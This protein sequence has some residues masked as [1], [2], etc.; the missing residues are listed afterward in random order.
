MQGIQMIKKMMASIAAAT[1]ICSPCVGEEGS[2]AQ[3]QAVCN[4]IGAHLYQVET[5]LGEKEQPNTGESNVN[6]YLGRSLDV[7]FAVRGKKKI[8]LSARFSKDHFDSEIRKKDV[9]LSMLLRERWAGD[10]F[11]SA[12]DGSSLR[13]KFERGEIREVL[14]TS[15]YVD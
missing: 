2:R 10:E 13:V 7:N 5:E 14:I 3:Y 9:F 8:I 15:D 4:F 11:S 6:S 1:F 12:C